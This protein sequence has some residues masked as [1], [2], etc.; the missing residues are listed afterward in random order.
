MTNF[1]RA[2]P[3][4][5]NYLNMLSTKS[6]FKAMG[7]DTVRVYV[8]SEDGKAI[9]CKG[10]FEDGRRQPKLGK[11]RIKIERSP[12]T[13][14]V[15]SKKRGELFSYS[16]DRIS[17][18]EDPY[19]SLLGKESIDQWFEMPILDTESQ[20]VIGLVCLFNRKQ[21]RTYSS[22]DLSRLRSI[23]LQIS[24]EL[25][26]LKAKDEF[27]QANALIKQLEQVGGAFLIGLGK[28]TPDS[29]WETRALYAEVLTSLYSIT[30][31]DAAELRN[32]SGQR[33][34]SL[35]FTGKKPIADFEMNLNNAKHRETLTGK[36]V[37]KRL[38]QYHIGK[39]NEKLYNDVFGPHFVK[40]E[41]KQLL[42]S[43]RSWA[44]RPIVVA[45][46][47][48]GVL[49]VASSDYDFLDN[50]NRLALDIFVNRFAVIMTVE[51]KV[52]SLS[53]TMLNQ[54][55][56]IEQQRDLVE[57][58]M[59][60]N[61]R[62][63]MAQVIMHEFGNGIGEMVLAFGVLKKAIE[64]SHQLMRSGNIK[65]SLQ[66][67]DLNFDTISTLIRSYSQTKFYPDSSD[68]VP[69]SVAIEEACQLVSSRAKRWQLY[70]DI[71]LRNKSVIMVASKTDLTIVF[72]NLLHNAIDSMKEGIGA[73]KRINVRGQLNNGS[74]V[75]LITDLGCGIRAKDRKKV[76][77]ADFST[78]WDKGGTGFGL[79]S[80]R[81]IVE[82]RYKGKVRIKSSKVG[83][84]TTF[85]IMLPVKE[86]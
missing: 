31:A 14:S 33:L 76:F 69:I 8:K 82:D 44:T 38:P 25:T 54:R 11:E 7:L 27:D 85:E 29:P 17:M 65:E 81:R 84:G 19:R 72:F 34:I 83:K 52:G 21:A 61:I 62:S 10:L 20:N 39:I 75:V 59:R 60:W 64:K 3:R 32:L 22:D 9:V 73:G 78:K 26:A 67:L 35:A 30:G 55:A 42:F 41:S 43:F 51:E 37:L 48:K 46:G 4:T 57:R 15:M 50:T 71:N 13:N 2:W 74:Y 80:V 24:L 12:F 18:G 1:T 47:V 68:L 86:G 28:I 16:R 66:V 77:D 36:A 63:E 49:F 56:E 53:D 23:F 40:P 45:G 58:K 79:Y 70:I 5:S 6:A